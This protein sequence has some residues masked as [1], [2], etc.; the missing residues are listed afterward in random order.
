[1]DGN[2]PAGLSH[3]SGIRHTRH[4]G[5]V[6]PRAGRPAAYFNP[7]LRPASRYHL[8]MAAATRSFRIR[9]YPNGAQRRMLDRWMGASRWLWN[10]A[11][12]IRS[13]G[14]KHCGLKLCGTDLSRWL[15]QWKRTAGHEWLADIPATCLTQCLRDQ[16]RAFSN[17]FAKRAR[18]PRFKRKSLSGSLRFQDVGTAWNRGSLNLPKLGAL[19]LAEA[20]PAAAKPDTVTLT[21]DSAGRYHVSFSAEVEIAL[22]PTT[23]RMIGADLGLTHLA[24]LSSGEKIKNPRH[25]RNRL[26]YLR[27]QQRALARKA[28]GSKRR[29]KQK[30]RV[31]RAHARVADQRS[32]AIHNLTARLVREFDVIAIEDLNVKGLARGLHAKSMH[33]AAFG[34]FR[35]QLTYK[36]AWYGRTLVAC[37]RF[38]PSSKTCSKCAHKLDELRLDVRQWTCPKCGSEHDRDINAAQNLLVAAMLQI[39]GRD[40]RDLLVDG[41]S[42]CTLARA[43]QV[44]PDEARSGQI[45]ANG[46]EREHVI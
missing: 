18:Y 14:Y 16:D 20:L 33:D 30:L 24:T 8:R 5:N 15:T 34:E 1:M 13:E 32:N 40:G 3:L 31:A 25:Y 38:F 23:G 22:L 28:K 10:T 19:N 29:E 11:L 4:Y 44:P 2:D 26:R 42:A 17:F 21:R 36:C 27:Q 12:G 43:T 37:D 41:G 46:T 6:C 9:A 45:Q 35:R 7:A 39:D